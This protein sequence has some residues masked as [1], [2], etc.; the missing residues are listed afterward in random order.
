M[1][2]KPERLASG[3]PLAPTMMHPQHEC[4]SFWQKLRLLAVALCLTV[5][6]AC[7]R[8]LEVLSSAPSSDSSHQLPFDRTVEKG[9]VSPTK[10]LS[11]P[12]A[13]SGTEIVVRLDSQLSS[14]TCHAG[15]VF[16]ATLQEPI[17]VK[18]QSLVPSGAEIVGRVTAVSASRHAP[19]YLRLTLSSVVIKGNA[20][21]LHT[22]SVFA[23]GKI[24]DGNTAP[25]QDARFSTGR[26]LTFHLTEPLS[27][28]T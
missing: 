1:T 20:L 18:G 22:S 15:D 27:P 7:S 4:I 28:P 23:K 16:Q 19:G 3:L 26:R 11:P 25:T 14:A 2:Y 12:T 24:K 8:Q 17:V 5:T 9:G 21:S 10:T 13:P 6:V